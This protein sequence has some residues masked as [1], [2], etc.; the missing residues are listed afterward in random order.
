[1]WTRTHSTLANSSVRNVSIDVTFTATSSRQARY[2]G[3]ARIVVIAGPAV[4]RSRQ[5]PVIRPLVIYHNMF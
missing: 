3:G 2:G 4:R 1:V 5:A